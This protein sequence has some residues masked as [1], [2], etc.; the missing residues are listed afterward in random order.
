M[1]QI[2]AILVSGHKIQWTEKRKV[3][4]RKYGKP[5]KQNRKENRQDGMGGIS[6]CTGTIKP[7]IAVV[8]NPYQNQHDADN[9][10]RKTK[11]QTVFLDLFSGMLPKCGSSHSQDKIIQRGEYL[12]FVYKIYGSIR[13]PSCAEIPDN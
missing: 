9:G 7:V 2:D 13:N 3:H 5:D 12:P 11:L 1:P 4:F 10:S 8:K 6:H